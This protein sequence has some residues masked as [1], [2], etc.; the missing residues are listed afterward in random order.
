MSLCWFVATKGIQVFERGARSALSSVK[1][2]ELTHY[3]SSAHTSEAG[4][5]MAEENAKVPV[6]V[7]TGFLG[8]GKTTLVNHILKGAMGAVPVFR[9]PAGCQLLPPACSLVADLPPAW[10]QQPD[11]SCMEMQCRPCCCI[12]TALYVTSQ[13][14]DSAGN[15]G[16]RIA[17]I[18][19]EFGEQ[20]SQ[21]T[22]RAVQQCYWL[23]IHAATALRNPTQHIVK[24]V[25]LNHSISRC[26]GFT[27]WKLWM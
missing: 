21:G 10:L 22:P 14:P 3:A 2:R 26:A 25:V 20:C 24:A 5:R 7:V 27:C 8:A 15:H 4:Y 9:H 13:T 17:V 12:T 19:N 1:E 16:K 23:A 6:T 11:H 18:E